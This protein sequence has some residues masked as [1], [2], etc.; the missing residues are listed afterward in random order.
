M[1]VDLSDCEL[2]AE[3][4]GFRSDI[5][6]LGRRR[7]L[8]N[9]DI[10]TIVLHRLDGFTGAVVSATT[11]NAP[12]NARSSYDKAMRE[13]SKKSGSKPEKAISELQKAVDEYPQFAAAWTLMGEAYFKTNQPDKG[14][15]ALEKAIEADPAY[16]RPYGPLVQHY[17]SHKDWAKTAETADAL[18]AMNP[19]QTQV[20][21]YKALGLY[22]SNQFD[23]AMA[24][25]R[26]IQEGPDAKSFPQTH[27]MIGMIQ[28]NRGEFEEAATEY[29]RYLEEQPNAP[30]AAE[31]KKQL[32]EWE[33]LGV[34]NPVKSASAQ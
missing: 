18:L 17:I 22:G 34:I 25:A 20:H 28:Q 33:V 24:V 19:A 23:D 3:L 26:Q 5:L 6:Q 8:D 16:M 11:L 10:G 29:R 21:Y 30:S 1:S 12:K 4:P 9:P 15:A 14:A 31:L 2:Q 27:Q 32:M 7:T 13:M